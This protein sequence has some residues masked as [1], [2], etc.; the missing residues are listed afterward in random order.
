MQN[1]KNRLGAVL[2]AVAIGLGADSST[3]FAGDR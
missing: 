3:I 1:H 2:M